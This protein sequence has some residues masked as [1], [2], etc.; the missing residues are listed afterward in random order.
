MR[1]AEGAEGSYQESEPPLMATNGKTCAPLLTKA[2]PG[3]SRGWSGA[4]LHCWAGLPWETLAH[5]PLHRDN[6]TSMSNGF[7]QHRCGQL[8]GDCQV[9]GVP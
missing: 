8:I 5:E 3:M 6:L 1:K 9:L 4:A 7:L 2:R